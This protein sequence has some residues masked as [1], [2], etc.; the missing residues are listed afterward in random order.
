MRRLAMTPR[1]DWQ[2]KAE[3]IGFTFHSHGSDPT[4]TGNEGVY[5]DESVAYEFTSDEVDTI[6]AA[7]NDLH[8]RVLDAVDFVVSNRPWIMESFGITPEW[9]RII[10][11][12]WRRRDPSIMGRFDLPSTP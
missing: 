4:Q 5:W 6:E 11:D 10:G 9:R 12:S 1:P 8:A 3:E 2:A 7:T